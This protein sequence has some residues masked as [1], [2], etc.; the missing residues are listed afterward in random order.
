MDSEHV[1]AKIGLDTAENGPNAEG[2]KSTDTSGSEVPAGGL[3]L[4]RR[5]LRLPLPAALRGA[6]RLRG[7]LARGGLRLRRRPP[8]P[9]GRVG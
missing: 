5:R 9:N 7:G 2:A 6:A 8:G 4:Q 1:L 3:Q